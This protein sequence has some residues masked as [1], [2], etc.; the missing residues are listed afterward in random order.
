MFDEDFHLNV[1]QLKPFRKSWIND[2]SHLL[3]HLTSTRSMNF[4][5]YSR[6]A[7]IRGDLNLFEKRRP[8]NG[9]S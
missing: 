5:W 7:G 1:Q 4:S 8:C 9:W 3:N 6:H 2:K